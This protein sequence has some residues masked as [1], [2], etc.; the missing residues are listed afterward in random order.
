MK[1][2]Y[3]DKEFSDKTLPIHQ[4]FCGR[5]QNTQAPVKKAVKSQIFKPKKEQ[6]AET[7][8][9]HSLDGLR[10]IAKAQGVAYWWVKSEEKLMKELGM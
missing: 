9:K 1:C 3:C 6:V 5:Q 10:N 2:K 8:S 4:D 7:N